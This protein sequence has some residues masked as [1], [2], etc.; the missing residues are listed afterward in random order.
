MSEYPD[1]SHNLNAEPV[2]TLCRVLYGEKYAT[3]GG[4]QKD[5][6]DNQSPAVQ[7]RLRLALSEAA[8]TALKQ[9]LK[10]EDLV[11]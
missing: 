4:G 2:V 7:H 3:Q 10:L 5:F 11:L 6:W 8:K 1:Q 9:G